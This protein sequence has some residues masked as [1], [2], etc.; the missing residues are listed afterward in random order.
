[1]TMN[2]TLSLLA[3]LLLLAAAP[4]LSLAQDAAPTPIVSGEQVTLH[5]VT[6]LMI[7]SRSARNLARSRISLFQA[8]SCFAH[9]RICTEKSMYRLDAK[10]KA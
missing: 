10:E 1:M 9:L 6:R 4:A 5:S 2:R 8:G 7:T 3:A